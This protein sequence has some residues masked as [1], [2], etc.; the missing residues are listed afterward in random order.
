MSKHREIFFA[1]NGPG[2]WLCLGCGA[3]VEMNEVQVHH[4]DENHENNTS[5]NLSAMHHPCHVR[6]H[7]LGHAKSNEHRERLSEALRGR[8]HSDAA[9]SASFGKVLGPQ[10]D[11][12]K[13]KIGDAN[14]GRV[15]SD[16]SRAA[17]SAGWARRKEQQRSSK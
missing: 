1:R 10:S 2:P 13:Q 3:P 9:R 11:K 12:H 4:I 7:R 5:E 17:M 15:H 6:L 16:E 14:R 8:P